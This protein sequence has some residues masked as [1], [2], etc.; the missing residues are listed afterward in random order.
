MR[1]AHQT[2]LLCRNLP[3]E[4]SGTLLDCFGLDQQ[5]VLGLEGLMVDLE[6]TENGCRRHGI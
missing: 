2:R 1:L 6:T 3:L 4:S 5:I